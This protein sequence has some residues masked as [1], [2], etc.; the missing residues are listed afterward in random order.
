MRFNSIIPFIES[1]VI[2]RKRIE[3]IKRGID[4]SEEAKN[5]FSPIALKLALKKKALPEYY[6]AQKK[7]NWYSIAQRFLCSSKDLLELNNLKEI[8]EQIEGT[9]VRIPSS[10]LFAFKKRAGYRTKYRIK[11]GLEKFKLPSNGELT[12]S[13]GK[14][15]HP[16]K[17]K[18]V[19]HPGI[20][21]RGPW[22]TEVLAAAS[23]KVFFS[24]WA[25]AYGRLLVI[26][27]GN[28]FKTR[29]GHLQ[30]YFFKKGQKVNAG[31]VI[32][33][34]GASGRTTGRHLHFEVRLN[35]RTVDPLIFVDFPHRYARKRLK[36]KRPP[37]TGIG[38][39]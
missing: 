16:L 29:Y 20:D 38:P 21:I 22:R 35:E 6:L 24:G 5:T 4:K 32:G 37:T 31:D 28:G 27:H 23:G 1:S 25:G 17:R 11:E 33:L 19:F 26:D 15:F 30:K 2:S 36:G 10:R 8:P 18:K 12:S 3:K 14:R 39:L 9:Y 34:M 13:Y 7:D